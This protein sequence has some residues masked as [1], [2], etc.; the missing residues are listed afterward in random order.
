V[1]TNTYRTRYRNKY[2]S[3]G[4]ITEHTEE[5]TNGAVPNI[6]SQTTYVYNSSMLPDT[7]TYLANFGGNMMVYVYNSGNLTESAV[8]QLT[9]NGWEYFS[10]Q[11]YTYNGGKLVELKRELW[12]IGTATWTPSSIDSFIAAGPGSDSTFKRLI[13]TGSTYTVDDSFKFTRDAA[14]RILTDSSYQMGNLI[15]ADHFTYDAQGRLIAAFTGGTN[16]T[17]SYN[18]QSNLVSIQKN[19]PGWRTM[20]L[21][22]YNFA[23]QVT[24]W[25]EIDSSII[26]GQW[27][28]Y[29]AQYYYYGFPVSVNEVTTQNNLQLY[30]VPAT[31]YVNLSMSFSK[32]LQFSVR[33]LDMQGRLLSQWQEPAQKTYN[34]QIS[35]TGMAAGQYILHIHA[36]NES[37]SRQFSVI[38]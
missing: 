12:Q 2:N 34:K 15:R 20:E 28:P 17:Y 11:F 10:R 23:N 9:G 27:E 8:H 36:A 1:A 25:T 19:S 22:T 16:N 35:L 37:C 7:V 3:A 18:A 32:P 6:T 4:L 33:I 29:N 21:F 31:S 13:A 5:T 14:N 26:T 30:P 24:S 38:R